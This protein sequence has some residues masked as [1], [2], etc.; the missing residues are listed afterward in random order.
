MSSPDETFV[1]EVVD[2]RAVNRHGWDML[3]LLDDPPN[4]D[5][6]L[7]R[8]K[9]DPFE[10]IPWDEVRRVLCVAA[11]G[12]EQAPLFA[13]LGYEVTVVDLSSGQLERDRQVAR[14]LDLSIECVQADM[15]DL[16]ALAGRRFD[17]V[18]QPVSACYIPDVYRL[19]AQIA[20]VTS[21]A[22]YYSV[23][24]WAPGQLQVARE[25][26]WDNT[27]YRVTS[28]TGSREPILW[29][30]AV[31]WTGDRATC[32]HYAHT[33]GELVG[34]LCD[35]G[36]DIIGLR[37]PVVG[38]IQAPPASESHLAAYFPPYIHILARRR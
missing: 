4:V 1:G 34:G 10:W 5:A 11:G 6:A 9:L 15:V 33:F 16:S 21:T 25:D 2:Y 24:H 20:A 36:F 8:S 19:Y 37:E 23:V 3:S 26:P 13:A 27:A 35:A 31:T 22:G 29:H 7:A 17:L 14:E 28:P 12:G 38:D 18:Y 30:S 32:V